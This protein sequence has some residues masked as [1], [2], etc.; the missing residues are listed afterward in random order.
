MIK[1][2]RLLTEI[3]G[4][5]P[6]IARPDPRAMTAFGQWGD[7]WGDESDNAHCSEVA[8]LAS[9]WSMRLW[10][11]EAREVAELQ[12]GQE[13]RAGLIICLQQRLA[14]TQ[15]DDLGSQSSANGCDGGDH[16]ASVMSESA[17]DVELPTF[18]RL[19]RLVAAGLTGASAAD[20]VEDVMTLYRLS[21]LFSCAACAQTPCS[22][23]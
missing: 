8:S 20:N 1:T 10:D 2:V 15:G 14:Q 9:T 3:V 12:D 23:L 22:E 18:L 21:C 5:L 4:E 17:V 16:P 6:A 7:T 19:G 11:N 13:S